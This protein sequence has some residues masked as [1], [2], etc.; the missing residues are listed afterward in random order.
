MKSKARCLALMTLLVSTASWQHMNR[1]SQLL[2]LLL[3]L[4]LLLMLVVALLLQQ[5]QQHQHWGL[6][7]Q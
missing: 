2:L 1:S 5:Q 4:W 7:Q 6:Q 3:L